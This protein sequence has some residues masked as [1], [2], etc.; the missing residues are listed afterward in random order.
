MT[1]WLFAVFDRYIA[2]EVVD[3]EAELR[4]A[5]QTTRDYLA[6]VGAIPPFDPAQGNPQTFFDQVQACQT[7]VDPGSE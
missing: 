7:A 6:C 2:G 1:N 4:T 3:L 5:E